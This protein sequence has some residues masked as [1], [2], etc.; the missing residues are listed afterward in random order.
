[1][2]TPVLVQ[3]AD[4]IGEDCERL[5][6]ADV[7]ELQAQLNCNLFACDDASTE[8]FDEANPHEL[9]SMMRIVGAEFFFNEPC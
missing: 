6:I 9:D 1:M 2:Y 4:M 5:S 3:P 7:R 8:W